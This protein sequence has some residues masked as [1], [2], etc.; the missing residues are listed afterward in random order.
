MSNDS[1]RNGSCAASAQNNATSS[2]ALWKFSRAKRGASFE[3]SHATT[4]PATTEP[5]RILDARATSF[6]SISVCP[7][8][9]PRSS[10]RSAASILRPIAMKA[11]TLERARSERRDGRRYG[12]SVQ[13]LSQAASEGLARSLRSGILLCHPDAS[14]E[15]RLLFRTLAADI[16]ALEVREECLANRQLPRVAV[17]RGRAK[18]AARAKAHRRRR[19]SYPQRTRFQLSIGRLISH[20]IENDPSTLNKTRL[21]PK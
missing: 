11:A 5:V 8:P 3:I 17:L 16:A 9:Q 12:S 15:K 14:N 18:D 2:P 1:S 4:L 10:T 19:E 13:T 7:E 6:A 21:A 20:L